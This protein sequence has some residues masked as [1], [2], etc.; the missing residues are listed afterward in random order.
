MGSQGPHA[1]VME[2]IEGG[3]STL[4]ALS[5]LTQDNMIRGHG[6]RFLDM[7]R[8]IERGVN[9]TRMMRQFA[10][11]DATADDLDLLLDLADSQITYR[12]RYLEGL[13]LA[14]VRDLV[15]LDPSNPRST[16]FQIEAL[17]A[18][19]AALPV[20]RGDGM[21]EEPQKLL[22]RISAETEAEEAA[23]LDPRRALVIEQRLLQLSEAIATR[24][25]LQGSNAT[26]TKKSTGLA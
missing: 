9:T 12:A 8:R 13:A 11:D 19:V 21:P 1:E 5:G 23:R 6:W 4:A 10:P 26:P 14:P 22:A 15:M 3:L 18:H 7:A 24:Y 20:L 25:F 17:K 2:R 16:A